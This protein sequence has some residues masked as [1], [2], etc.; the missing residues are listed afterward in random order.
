VPGRFI[1]FEGGEGA[2]KSTQ[3]VRLAD[4]LRARGFDV[5]TTR[6]PG[7]TAGAEAI[8]ALLVNGEPGRW[9]GAAEALLMNAAR[10]DHVERLIRPA[11][12]RGAWVLTDRFVHST[13]AYQGVARGLDV[14][15][16]KQ[17]HSFATG[18]LW[19]DL[20]FVLDV[21]VALGL[22]RAA[23]RRDGEGRFEA[24]GT[25]FHEAVRSAMREFAAAPDCVLIDAAVDID[26]VAGAVAV[27]VEARF[28][29]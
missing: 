21:P 29:T 8:R 14:T 3:I 10:A 4:H 28:S 17:L 18:D 11:L 16:L 9:S 20:T 27:A 25:A 13:L 7:G 26:K 22:S 6:E 23:A 19:P 2:G 15:A 1:S 24:A 12:A 5:V